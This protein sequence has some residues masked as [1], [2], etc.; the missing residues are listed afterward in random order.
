MKNVFGL[1]VLVMLAS[2][3]VCFNEIGK[4]KGCSLEEKIAELH[5]KMPLNKFTVPHHDPYVFTSEDQPE[6][7][8]A[9]LKE[10]DRVCGIQFID[11]GKNYL[12]KN[13]ESSEA[14]RNAGYRVTHFGICGFCSNLLDLSI[15]LTKD[16]TKPARICG[17][18]SFISSEWTIGCLTTTIGFTK[19]CAQIWYWNILNTRKH[20]KWVCMWSWAR[21]EPIVVGGRI[22]ECIQ[23]DEE[24]SGDFF[25]FYAGRNRRN[26]GILS[27]LTREENAVKFISHCY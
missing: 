16:L 26:S 11:Q 10:E 25:K 20:C 14:A 6:K 8:K 21:G 22:N 19:E 15:Y 12:L 9:I 24:H 23:C 17:A 1:M 27:E 3:V 13:F 18:K 7:I 2:C 5:N 4:L